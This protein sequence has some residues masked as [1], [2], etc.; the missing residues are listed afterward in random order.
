VAQRF[1][2]ESAT[3]ISM[4]KDDDCGRIESE[5]GGSRDK[6]EFSRGLLSKADTSVD[7]GLLYCRLDFEGVKERRE[8]CKNQLIELKAPD[9]FPA[10]NTKLLKTTLEENGFSSRRAPARDKSYWGRSVR[11]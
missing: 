6:Q 8:I 3:L 2:E 11:F 9:W 4:C 10:T 7:A 1:F 5:T